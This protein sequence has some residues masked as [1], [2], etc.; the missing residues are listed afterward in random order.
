MDTKGGGGKNPWGGGCSVDLGLEV[1]EMKILET[2]F[3][4]NPDMSNSIGLET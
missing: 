4:E 2:D 3:Q 1:C